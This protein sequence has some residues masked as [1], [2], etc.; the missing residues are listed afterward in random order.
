MQVICRG[1]VGVA[2]AQHGV[3]NDPARHSARS[4]R[5]HR[6]HPQ[7]LQIQKYDYSPGYMRY[8]HDGRL[9]WSAPLREGWLDTFLLMLIAAEC[10]A[11]G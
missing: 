1:I 2:L 11:G 8:A 10:C 5:I 6:D 9:K 4:R 3:G 7:F